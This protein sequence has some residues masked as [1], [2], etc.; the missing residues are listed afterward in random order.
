M[1]IIYFAIAVLTI[2]HIFQIWSIQKHKE[3]RDI[4]ISYNILQ[5]IGFSF[6]TYQAYID[7]SNLYIITQVAS[8]IPVMIIIGQL[9]YHR[10]DKWHDDSDR[11]C[12]CEHEIEVDWIRCPYCEC[13]CVE[14]MPGCLK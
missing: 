8:I 11:M 1:M 7:G 9:I 14:D 6:L 13:I 10:K 5:V 3:V 12:S 4:S 2:S